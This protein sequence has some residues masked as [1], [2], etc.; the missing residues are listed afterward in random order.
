M[1]AFAHFI[2]YATKFNVSLFKIKGKNTKTDSYENDKSK[3]N[4]FAS[5]GWKR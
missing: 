4:G 5:I 3:K 1:L 2:I